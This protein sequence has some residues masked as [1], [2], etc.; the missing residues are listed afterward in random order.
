[1]AQSNATKNEEVAY[2]ELDPNCEGIIYT[3][4]MKNGLSWKNGVTTLR[5]HADDDSRS[6]FPLKCLDTY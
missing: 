3:V 2:I 1:M 4:L 6:E 5:D